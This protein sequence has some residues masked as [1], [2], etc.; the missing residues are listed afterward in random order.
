MP[1]GDAKP[2]RIG[3]FGGT[4]DPPHVG[5]LVTAVNVRH[6]LDLD[7]MLLMVNNVPWQKVGSRP[8][9]PA[10]DRLAMVA[11]AVADVDGLE[12]GDHEIEAG[13]HSFTAD[14]LAT[15]GAEYPG[16][17]LFTVVGDDAAAGIRT[18]ERADEVISRSRMVVVD[19]PGEHAELDADVD[20]V[21]VEV[22]RLEVSSTD[23]RARWN[24]G[25]PLDYL[26][27]DEVLAVVAERGLYASEGVA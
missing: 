14:T 17:E 8:I 16:A 25:R 18:W 9:T 26:V 15:L 4:F 21:R 3:V 22:P 7:L 5:H 6:A 12:A 2:L 20:W 19:R 24:D 27:T 23:L 11:A 1:P 10:R 13:G